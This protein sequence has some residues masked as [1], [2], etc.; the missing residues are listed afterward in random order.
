MEKTEYDVI[1]AGSGAGGMSAAVTAAKLGLDVIVLEKEPLFG[2]TTARSGG[3][4]WLPGNPVSRAMGFADS[5]EEARA[6]LKHETN[7]NYD[8]DRVDAFLLT[9][10]EAAQF[11]QDNTAVKFDPLMTFPD[12]HPSAPGAVD[13]GRS[14]VAAPFSGLELGKEIRRLRPP[15][16]EITFVGMMFNASQEIQHFFNVTRSLKS[17]IYVVKR[18]SKHVYEMLRYGRAIRLTNGNA[19]AARLAKS[20][21]D[22]N[23]PIVTD[24]PIDAVI[25]DGDAVTGVE[26]IIGGKQIRLVA[27]RGVVLATG[28]FPQDPALR[29]LLFP[30]APTGAEHWSPAPP[31]NTG[32]G[33]RIASAIGGQTTALPNAAAWIPVSRVPYGNGKYGVFPHL[34]D[35]YKPGIIAVNHQ[36]RRFVNEANS[37]HDFGQAMQATCKGQTEVSAYLICDHQTLRRYGLGFAKPFPVPY[38][39]HLWSGYLVQGNS[40]AQ[41]AHKL[42]MNPTVLAETVKKVN[43]DA[44]TGTDTEFGKGSTSY[45][46]YLGDA[47]HPSNACFAAIERGPFYALKIYMGDLGTFAGIKTN[48]T[49]QV[50]NQAGNAVPGLYAVGNDAASVMGGNYPGAGITLGPALTFGYIVGRHLAGR[51]N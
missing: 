20:L 16:K 4:L 26:V 13:G 44:T 45:N 50:I 24:C 42:G 10:P 36:G 47:N 48:S 1:V 35:R 25:S 34:I 11:F 33:W 29:K 12:Y 18:L 22:L 28:G 41:L 30:H 9:A 40:I 7:A 5:I 17:A 21:F 15:L 14:V 38:R 19:L 49:A 8:A 46:R 37:Y 6:Y 32:D 23:V 39:Q 3:V 51:N 27:R 31:G 43:A 2:G